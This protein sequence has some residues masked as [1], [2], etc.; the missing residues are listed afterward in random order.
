M[1]E[2]VLF[3]EARMRAIRAKAAPG[4]RTEYV[5]A[6]VP[7]LRLRVSATAAS[8]SVLKRIPGGPMRRVQLGSADELAV[9][10][11]RKRAQQEV[12]KLLEGRDPTAERRERSAAARRD[13]LTLAEALAI[14][15]DEK[16]ALRPATR[17]TYERDLRTTF[18]DYLDRPLVDLTPAKVRERHRHRMTRPVKAAAKVAHAR[19]RTRLT[20]SPARADGA[21]RALRAVV[22]YV[23][24]TRGVDL[25]DPAAE[26]TAVR[27]WAN[28]PR[29]KRALLGDRLAEFVKALRAMPDDLPPD[30]T[31]TQRDL[32]LL[33]LCTGLRL[34]SAAGLQWSEVD[35]KAGTLTIPADRMKGKREHT[36]PLGPEML[37]VLERRREARRSAVYVFAG[38]DPAEGSKRG[39][40]PLERLSARFMARLVDSEGSPFAWSP[41]DLRRT[42]LTVL[43]SM[44]VSA[45]A[46]KRIAAHS[47]AGDVTAGYLAD[48]VERLRKPMER[49]EL[50]VLGNPGKVVAMPKGRAKR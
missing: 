20:A 3:T 14:Y 44:D 1:A 45:Y 35:F 30:L 13:S 17:A 47:Q 48:D 26:V 6:K 41:H 38:A 8:W 18:G 19:D 16:P 7:S 22:R 49:L 2:K 28:V 25:P 46:L 27:Q 4:A 36:L 37:G 32:V 33:L 34:G 40:A 21:V 9:E 43:E 29:R 31:G 23:R 42:A 50:A 39:H 12:A 10:A 24:A 15:L 5:D 11:A